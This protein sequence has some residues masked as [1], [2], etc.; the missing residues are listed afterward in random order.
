LTTNSPDFFIRPWEYL[1]GLID[2]LTTGGSEQTTPTQAIVIIFGTPSPEAH[3]T[4]A[5]G[6]GKRYVPFLMVLFIDSSSNLIPKRILADNHA[7]N[8][9]RNLQHIYEESADD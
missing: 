2:T 8:N 1:L 4:I 3:D 5:V 6:V 7:E 9:S